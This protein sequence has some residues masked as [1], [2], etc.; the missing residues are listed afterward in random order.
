MADEK[1]DERA[2][3]GRLREELFWKERARM[4]GIT[5][6]ARALTKQD[7]RALA[8]KTA[9][10][11]MPDYEKLVQRPQVR[12]V[13][14]YWALPPDAVRTIER[15]VREGKSENAACRWVWINVLKGDP[16]DEKGWKEALRLYRKNHRKNKLD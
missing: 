5:P 16:N 3:V 1:D 4:W 10:V 9:E 12:L 14:G 2:A 6:S 11:Y 7:W 13:R 8:I 15:M